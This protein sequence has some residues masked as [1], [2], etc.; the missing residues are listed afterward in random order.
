MPFPMTFDIENVTAKKD[1]TSANL[2]SGQINGNPEAVYHLCVSQ[3]NKYPPDHMCSNA[4]SE[5]DAYNDI[6]GFNSSGVASTNLATTNFLPI[7]ISY[8]YGFDGYNTNMST[9]LIQVQIESAVNT[10]D[11]NIDPTI[12]A[13]AQTVNN[14]TKYNAVL[15]Y[16]NLMVSR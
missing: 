9:D 13:Q 14:L 12:R 5:Y 8:Q 6:A 3:Q 11:A 16:S 10:A 1:I 2:A 7:G 15:P 4:K